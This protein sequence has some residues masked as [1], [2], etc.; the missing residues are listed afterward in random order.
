MLLCRQAHTSIVETTKKTMLGQVIPP[1]LI[2]H[3]KASMGEDYVTLWNGSTVHFVGLDNPL[4]WYSSEI[5]SIGFDEAQEITEDSAVRLITRLRQPGMPHR[6]S[7]TFNPSSPGHWLQKWFLLGGEQ[8]KFGFRKPKLYA[9]EAT[10]PIG[11]AEFIFAKATDN[12]Y[13]PEGYVE[14]TLSGL[15]ERLRRRYLDGLWE[16]TEGNGFFDMEALALYEREA[17]ESTPLLVGRTT[18]SPEQDFTYRSRKGRPDDP[19]RFQ[20]GDG[21]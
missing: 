1:E 4:R 2:E 17:H 7:F 10:S 19:V 14:Q 8:T 9:S 11:D 20:R 16:F 12:I 6:A 15:P 5:G 21:P 3:Q 13:L 18:G